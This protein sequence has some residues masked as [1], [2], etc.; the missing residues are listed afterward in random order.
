[1]KRTSARD[2][3]AFKER[4]E[5]FA[6]LTCYDYPTARIL[7]SAGI[8]ILLVGDSVADNVLG[9]PNTLPVT[10]DE[11]IHHVK[12][13]ARGAERAFVVADMPFMSYQA[14]IEEGIRNAGRFLKEAGAHGV[15]LEGPQVGLIG[16]L[17]ERGIPTMAHLGLTPQSVNAIGYRVQGRTEES[18]RRLVEDAHAV[19]KA[20]AFAIV[21][22]AV[23][24]DLASEITASTDA[25]TIGI[26]AGPHC[27]GQV[28]VITDLIGLSERAPKLAK[29]Y[30]D[31]RGEIDRAAREFALEV[32]EGTFPDESHTYP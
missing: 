7:D 31:V 1:M 16:A 10:M 17:V 29:S 18:A 9:Y 6:M 3:R 22:E 5:R 25:P 19:A 32:A 14:S 20:G 24:P 8:P 30:A 26:G 28:L 23:P 11:M 13:V 12:A 21:L 2:I 15:K 4:G 27:D